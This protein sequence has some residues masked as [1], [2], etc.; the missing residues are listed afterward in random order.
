MKFA[1]HPL[2]T[3]ILLQGQKNSHVPVNCK[4]LFFKSKICAASF[5]LL[6]PYWEIKS[7]PE[8]DPKFP[9]KSDPD[10]KKLILDPQHCYIML[11]LIPTYDIFFKFWVM[12][13]QLIL[14]DLRF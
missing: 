11:F 13:V 9:E 14:R 12:L 2:V 3:S 4:N 6:P 5:F 10:P 8:P 7:D 1:E